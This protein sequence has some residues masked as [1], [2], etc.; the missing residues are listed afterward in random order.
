MSRFCRTGWGESATRPPGG[1][2]VTANLTSTGMPPTLMKASMSLPNPAFSCKLSR[3]VINSSAAGAAKVRC[4]RGGEE[5]AA[6]RDGAAGMGKWLLL[7]PHRL[8]YSVLWSSQKKHS[9]SKCL[10]TAAAQSLA[11]ANTTLTC[12]DGIVLCFGQTFSKLC[13]HLLLLRH[14]QGLIRLQY[15]RPAGRECVVLCDDFYL[16]SAAN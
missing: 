15:W 10:S 2:P 3:I 11:A 9:L 6:E 5:G 16:S 14:G 7:A 1:Q 4:H 8:W 12:R 13:L